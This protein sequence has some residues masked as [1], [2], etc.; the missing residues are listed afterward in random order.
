MDIAEATH[1]VA[2]LLPA[3]S[4]LSLADQMRRS[5]ISIPSNIAEGRMRA[6]DA[7]FKRFLSIAF[8]S[9]A[10]LETQLELARR[11]YPELQGQCG[12]I[13]AALRDVMPMMNRFISQ[14]TAKGQ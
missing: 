7:D 11:F 9:G 13:E 3:K 1:L 14:L 2:G 5:A 10:E 6:S 8:A 12:K 4:G